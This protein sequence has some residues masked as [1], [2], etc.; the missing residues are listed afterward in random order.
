[1]QMAEH[2]DE[3][4]VRPNEEVA[5]YVVRAR[6]AHKRLGKTWIYWAEIGNG[7][8][9]FRLQLADEIRPNDGRAEDTQRWRDSMTKF[10]HD[11]GWHE[12]DPHGFIK[13]ERVNLMH[14]MERIEEV[15]AF[16]AAYGE[17]EGQR[18][19]DRLNNPSA[20][21]K[22][23]LEHVGEAKPKKQSGLKSSVAQLQEEL[24][25]V[26]EENALLKEEIAGDGWE[27]KLKVIV[28]KTDAAEVAEVIWDADENSTGLAF[29]L[30][31]VMIAEYEKTC[32]ILEIVDLDPKDIIEHNSQKARTLADAILNE[33]DGQTDEPHD[34]R[35]ARRITNGR[36]PC[37][38]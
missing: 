10:L 37:P 3:G 14:C 8:L 16:R 19:L 34:D 21:W 4:L 28:T 38:R 17:A 35:L 24:D 33:L 27:E 20:V 23:F 2:V 6:E 29:D 30:T 15:E 31:E 13:A 26:I 22:R 1:M 11:N 36:G 25:A 5:K 9:A 7:L 12:K 32:S 18:K